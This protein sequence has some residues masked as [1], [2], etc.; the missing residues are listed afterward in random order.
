[1]PVTPPAL[2]NPP[3]TCPPTPQTV[4]TCA[5]KGPTP[6][7]EMGAQTPG[8]SHI[9]PPCPKW[10]PGFGDRERGMMKGKLR[11]RT[12]GAAATLPVP[13]SQYGGVQGP[14][15]AGS[16]DPPRPGCSPG[17][18]LGGRSHLPVHRGVH[19]RVY[20]CACMCTRVC[21]PGPGAAQELPAPLPASRHRR[22]GAGPDLSSPALA[23]AAPTPVHTHAHACTRTHAHVTSP[24]TMLCAPVSAPG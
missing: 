23:P 16:G 10:V 5:L 9:Q 8:F 6:P 7:P 19:M 4:G 22:V 3:H 18:Q 2:I 15:S 21:V 13:P 24:G 17:P 14:P 1:M 20:V 12:A 11:Q